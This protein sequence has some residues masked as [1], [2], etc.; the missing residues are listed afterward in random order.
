MSRRPD[1]PAPATSRP[2]AERARIAASPANRW[3]ATDQLRL[4]A[5]D[6]PGARALPAKR[7]GRRPGRPRAVE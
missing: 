2:P 4:E 7:P 1:D 3:L 5:L 6:E